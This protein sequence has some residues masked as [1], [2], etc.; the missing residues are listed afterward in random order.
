M[1][2]R[3]ALLTHSTNPRG[4]VVHAM[5]LAEALQMLGHRVVLHASDPQGRGFFRRGDS[6]RVSIPGPALSGPLHEMVEQRIADYVRYF[7]NASAASFDVYHAQDSISANA[8]AQLQQL[9]VI[10]GFVRTVHHLDRFADERLQ[11]LQDQVLPLAD[12]TF[13]VSKVWQRTLA[14]THAIAAKLVPSGVDL[15]RF[16]ANHGSADEVARRRFGIRSSGPIFLAIGGIEPRKNS[17]RLLQAFS[18]VAKTH[19]EAQL[20]IAGGAT[21]LDH[22]EY[23]DAFTMAA[24]ELGLNES[25]NGAGPRL[26]LTGRVED[27]ELSALYR[28]AGALVFPSVAEGFGLVVLEAMASG[29]PVIVSRIAPFTEHLP[30][31]TCLWVQPESVESLVAAMLQVLDDN[32]AESLRSYGRQLAPHF[33]W[34]ASAEAHLAHYVWPRPASDKALGFVERKLAHA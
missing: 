16:H 2:L 9:G 13:C 5:E 32:H 4:G 23:V 18:V 6:A 8:L 22:R 27:E 31:E 17:L 20:V 26:I 25:R 29:T 34:R 19:K 11:R 10:G 1:S 12:T 14:E 15:Q 21:V 28:L 7:K 24:T 3:I 30:E 33:T